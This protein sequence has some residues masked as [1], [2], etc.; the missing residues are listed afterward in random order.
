MAQQLYQ[1]P[2]GV[3]AGAAGLGQGFFWRLYARL[4]TD[5]VLDVFLHLLVDVDQEVVGGA[6]RTVD[7]VE[8]GLHQWCHGLGGQVGRQL[9][10]QHGVVAERELLGFGFE[11]VVERVV[12]RHF[13]HQVHGDLEFGGFLG[14]H[15]A[16]LVVGKRVLLPVHEMVG[17]LDLERIRDHIA[18]AMGCRAQPDDLGTEVD[19]AV[20]LVMG[21][22]VQGGVNGHALVFPGGCWMLLGTA[23]ISRNI[24]ILA[25]AEPVER[26]Q[27][28][29]QSTKT[30][31]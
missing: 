28:T 8:V 17:G 31:F 26:T 1:Q 27:T 4:H 12:D 30:T 19:R 5:Q 20:V 3:A 25:R 6:F 22:V 11:E 15:Q 23:G 29:R 13:H 24:R 16:C 14:E 2:A 10:F 21:N 7:F 9:L 18:A